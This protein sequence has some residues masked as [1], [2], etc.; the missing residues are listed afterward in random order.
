MD[1][2]FGATQVWMA[3]KAE[4]YDVVIGVDWAK[5]Q[6]YTVITALTSGEGKPRMVGFM[7]F[8]IAFRIVVMRSVY[9]ICRM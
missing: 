7:R 6:D 1:D 9:A 8:I 3:P 2:L 4:E 5:K